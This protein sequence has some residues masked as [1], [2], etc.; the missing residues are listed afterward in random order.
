M[1]DEIKI[2]K[3]KMYNSFDFIH[4]NRDIVRA[5]VKKLKIEFK[6][7]NNFMYFPIIVDENLN[8]IDGQHRFIACKELK[9][10]IYYVV[11]RGSSGAN[12]IRSVNKAGKK[13]TLI[14][15]FNMDLKMGNKEASK[16]NLIFNKLHGLVKMNVVISCSLD[17][18]D[19]GAVKDKLE[20]GDYFVKDIK[21]T[22]GF[23]EA[24]VIL[25]NGKSV[26]NT[27]YNSI[28][29]VSRKNNIDPKILLNNLINNNL[30]LSSKNSKTM[31][32]NKIIETYNFRRKSDNRI[33]I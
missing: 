30:Q 19:G 3:S 13:H 28:M 27:I 25:T 23:L 9:E 16:M 1:S 33:S 2:L 20:S 4:Y 31:I 7:E 15:I 12:S 5:T 24:L 10:P 14:D 6:K 8:I 22:M 18:S 11:K 21:K 29:Y 26:N 17:M 32:I